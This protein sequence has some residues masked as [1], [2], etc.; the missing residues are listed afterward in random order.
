ML[1]GT[2]YLWVGSQYSMGTARNMGPGF[3]PLLIGSLTLIIGCILILRG[4]LQSGDRPR[5]PFRPIVAIGA[6]IAAFWGLI[7]T[8]G[9]IAAIVGTVLLAAFAEPGPRPLRVA[10][11]IIFLVVLSWG[12]FVVALGMPLRMVRWP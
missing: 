6:S 2:G 3:F 1:F 8:F 7:N 5:F 11:L 9:L 10:A 12:V 4:A